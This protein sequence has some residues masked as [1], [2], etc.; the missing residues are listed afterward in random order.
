[1][2]TWVS[3]I[4]HRQAHIDGIVPSPFPSLEASADEGDNV[5]DDKDGASSFDDD[6]MIVLVTCPLSFVTKRG[7]SH[8]L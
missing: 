3:R 2:N 5:D 8:N 1:M 6:E 4:A 7:S